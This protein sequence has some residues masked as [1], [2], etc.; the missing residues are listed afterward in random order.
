MISLNVIVVNNKIPAF[1]I[2]NLKII[3]DAI[4]LN[5]GKT[6]KL[7]NKYAINKFHNKIILE[8]RLP[9]TALKDS[10]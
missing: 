8:K 10:K 4:L 3:M 2:R 1:F 7:N 6:F 9:L 5:I